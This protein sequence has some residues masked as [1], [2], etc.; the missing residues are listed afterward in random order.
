MVRR[1]WIEMERDS[2]GSL[3]LA[4]LKLLAS[5][6]VAWLLVLIVFCTVIPA[7]ADGAIPEKY[8]LT[9]VLIAFA[10][11]LFTNFVI[12]F[13]TVQHL[14]SSMLKSKADIIAVNETSA[15]LL[16]K[17]ERVVDGFTRIEVGMFEKFAEARKSANRIRSSR[18][19][20]AVVESYPE[21]KSNLS[22]QKLLSQLE[23]TEHAKLSARTSYSNAAAKYNAR[24]HSFPIVLLR[25]AFKWED[26]IV[27][28][29]TP[30]EQLVTDEELGI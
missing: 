12:D 4:L 10:L 19:F 8:N 25:R 27:S 21:L 29:G 26:E 11:S 15:S 13:N 1:D 9:I 2:N 7:A 6:I 22:V 16:N 18:D 14:K 23:S 5:F 30:K 3:I 24:I 20:H 17:A 28:E